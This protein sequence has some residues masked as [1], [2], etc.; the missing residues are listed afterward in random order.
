MAS[1]LLTL[2]G[3]ISRW[4]FDMIILRLILQIIEAVHN[5]QT[6]FTICMK[7]TKNIC[8]ICKLIVISETTLIRLKSGQSCLISVYLRN[9]IRTARDFLSINNR[10][11]SHIKMK[12]CD[13]GKARAWRGRKE[14][15]EAAVTV[16]L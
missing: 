6:L 11:K 2:C 15:D 9:L 14:S 7:F 13:G 12:L 1:Y 3:L 8:N 10:I 4:I 5:W 16:L